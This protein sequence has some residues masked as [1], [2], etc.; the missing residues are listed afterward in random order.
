MLNISLYKQKHLNSYLKADQSLYATVKV[1][2]KF[3]AFAVFPL[4]LG[5]PCQVLKAVMQKYL[6]LLNFAI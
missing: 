5:G 3:S 2:L 1:F 4:C 6:K